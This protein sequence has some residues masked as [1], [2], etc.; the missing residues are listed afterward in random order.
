MKRAWRRRRPALTIPTCGHSCR[1]RHNHE[2]LAL[3]RLRPDRQ[4]PSSAPF[5]SLTAVVPYC[6]RIVGNPHVC[7]LLHNAARIK[8]RIFFRNAAKQSAR[9]RRVRP[10]TQAWFGGRMLSEMLYALLYIF[11]STSPATVL[12]DTETR[13][14]ANEHIPEVQ[15]FG[16]ITVQEPSCWRR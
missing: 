12:M 1:R 7:A 3:N 16:R 9:S 2:G 10:N 13:W 11:C 5:N 4:Q 8:L 14:S 6:F 15:Q